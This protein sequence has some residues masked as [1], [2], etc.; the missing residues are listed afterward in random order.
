MHDQL[1][2]LADAGGFDAAALQRIFAVVFTESRAL[3]TEA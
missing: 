1:A 2:R 3:V